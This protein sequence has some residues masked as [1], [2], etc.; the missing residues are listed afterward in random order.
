MT[1]TVNP[2]VI[3]T[4]TQVA[5]ICSGGSLSALPTTSNNG[6]TGSWSP[7]LNTTTTTTYTFTPTAGLCATTATMTITVGNPIK[8]NNIDIIQP[9]CLGTSLG[10]INISAFGG[11]GVLNYTLGSALQTSSTFTGLTA[12]NYTI[13]IVDAIGCTATSTATI[14]QP[15]PI[16]IIQVNLSVTSCDDKSNLE[17]IVSGGTQPI[18][19]SINTIGLTNNTGYF[20][21]LNPGSY[22][23]NVADA[24]G[25][26]DKIL[27]NLS[28]PT[29]LK[30]TLQ[31]VSNGSCL[32]EN[33]GNILCTTLGGV[34]PYKYTLNPGNV[35]SNNGDFYNLNRGDY[36][37][38]TIDSNGCTTN[39]SITIKG[40]PC[41]DE[42]YIP[43]A[44]TP[45]ND[46]NNDEFTFLNALE[47]DIEL[48]D[49][50]IVNRFGNVVFK[51]N[52]FYDKWDGKYKGVS[53]D[54]GT[55]FYMLRYKCYTS[56]EIMIKKGDINLLR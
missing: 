11:F 19:Y 32:K 24:N 27:Y 10:T 18:T 35:N 25:C 46:N 23:I 37:I 21:G 3:P 1:I 38:T 53:C 5:A 6:I 26:T 4:F 7:S 8:I 39:N 17:I 55:Y 20:V 33:I 54:I 34:A 51:A 12:G 47:T 43:N 45:N 41:C 14:L 2:N 36:E 50:V 22:V 56:G 31:F 13:T 28:K 42:L 9:N 48:I 16:N 49:F 52:H 15:I 44:F 30:T 40:T 29:P